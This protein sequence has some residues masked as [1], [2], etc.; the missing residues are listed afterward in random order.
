MIYKHLFWSSYK[1]L[2]LQDILLKMLDVT[3]CLLVRKEQV[4]LGQKKSGF[5]QG[6]YNGYGGKPKGEE[7]LEDAAVRELFEET[8]VVA[9]AD[10]LQKRAELMFTFPHKPEWN[11]RVHVYELQTWEG[12]PAEST[13]MKPAWFS[14]DAV[15]YEKMWDAD[16]HWM[17][18]VLEGKYVKASFVYG[19]NKEVLEMKVECSEKI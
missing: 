2:C 13:E 16:R 1:F 14:I 11:Q 5:G 18:L 7:S 9:C 10:Y 19:E 6:N 4:S 15:P 12:E 17:P 3:L 8:G